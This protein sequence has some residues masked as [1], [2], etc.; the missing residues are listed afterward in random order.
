M[1][2]RYIALPAVAS[3]NT[4]LAAH[5]ASLPAGTVVHTPCQTAGRGQKGNHWESEPGKN[6]TF[7]LLLK[8]T[9]VPA[10]HQFCL[11]E[12][13]AVGIADALPEAPLRVKWP[14][15]IYFGDGKLAGILIENT[16]QGQLIEQCIAGVG[17]NVNQTVFTSDAPNPV[18]LRQITGRECDL[19]ALL[20]RVCESICLLVDTLPHGAEALHA[21]YRQLLYR[22]DGC[23]HPFALP[24]GERF[25]ATIQDVSPDGMLTLRHAHG[26]SQAYAFKQVK[27]IISEH[28]L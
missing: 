14:N 20:R 16:L 5:A 6:L 15:D 1:T 7:S 23:E 11:S 3:T 2:P 9:G 12:A 28:A 4:Y 24:G 17:L 19:D 22:N 8:D 21:R 18:S 13:V 26:G 25:M 27:H 10:R